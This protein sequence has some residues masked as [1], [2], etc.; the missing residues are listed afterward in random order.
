MDLAVTVGILH[1]V[2]DGVF[3]NR[4]DDEL[5]GIQLLHPRLHG[6]V[7]REL[8]LITHFLD[9]QI[10]PGVFDL[11]PDGNDVAAL[12]E[13]DPEKPG[14]RR[15]HDHSLLGPAVLRHPHHAIQRII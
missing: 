7:G 6:N 11:V 2:I 3:Q 8:I 1:A 5:D 13:R 10:I 4:L 15:Q 14:Q 9:G 12:A